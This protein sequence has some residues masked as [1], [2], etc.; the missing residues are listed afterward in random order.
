MALAVFYERI[1]EASPLVAPY[2]PDGSYTVGA[3]STGMSAYVNPLAL[4]EQTKDDY[5]TTRILANGYINYEF[6]PGFSLK[7]N[8]GIDKGAETRNQ[9]SP[10]VTLTTSAVSPVASTGVSSSV[11]NYSYTAESYLNYEKTIATNH[12]I[13]AL[14]G[15]SLQKFDSKSNSITG[16]GFPS[17]DIPYLSAASIISA[18]SS[19]TAQYS[20]LSAI[21]RLKL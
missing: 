5:I 11:D 13:E 2:N 20:L 18:G 9:F 3:F 1:F 12:H 17:D 14:A 8:V 16:T 4:L 19:T 6:L 10:S 7:T 15:Y 21:G